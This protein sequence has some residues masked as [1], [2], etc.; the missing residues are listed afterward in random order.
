MKSRAD[1][2]VVPLGK[3]QLAEVVLWQGASDQPEG[4]CTAWV[5][6]TPPP[7]IVT[8]WE[9]HEPDAGRA[10]EGTTTPRAGTA[11]AVF[12]AAPVSDTSV[13]VPADAAD[14][15][16]VSTSSPGATPD[17]PDCPVQYHADDSAS[18]APTTDARPLEVAGAGLRVPA[19]TPTTA[20]TAA[21]K[22][23]TRQ[24]RSGLW[25]AGFTDRPSQPRRRAPTGRPRRRR[26]PPGPVRAAGAVPSGA[27]RAG[28]APAPP[29][30]PPRAGPRRGRRGSS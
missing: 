20:T 5:T 8:S 25:W 21:T 22:T 3:Y 9:N 14:V 26:D 2:A 1:P 23:S 10:S 6:A 12:A 30:G 4:P 28:P 13:T 27:A 15:V 11:T 18:G 16:F 24:R 17:A 29:T 19:T 7:E